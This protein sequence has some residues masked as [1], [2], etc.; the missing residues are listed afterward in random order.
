MKFEKEDI[1]VEMRQ[2]ALVDMAPE[3][4]VENRLA[5]RRDLDNCAKVCCM[6]D[7]MFRDK[8]EAREPSN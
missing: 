5:G 3:A 1:S 4:V 2:A 6:I 7:D 8:R